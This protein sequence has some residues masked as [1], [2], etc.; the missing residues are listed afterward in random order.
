MLPP[1]ALAC[2]YLCVYIGRRCR[3]RARPDI[4]RLVQVAGGGFFI[5]H[6]TKP[7]RAPVPQVHLT[8]SPFSLS[9]STSIPSSIGG[10][11]NFQGD[12]IEVSFALE[13]TAGRKIAQARACSNCADLLTR[14][15]GIGWSMCLTVMREGRRGGGLIFLY[16]CGGRLEGL[17]GCGSKIFNR[18]GK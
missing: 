16:H 6:K 5:G 17:G 12:L 11:V 18:V 9:R 8:I 1:P 4:T 15:C 3:H 2:V 7:Q 14:P 13:W 10:N